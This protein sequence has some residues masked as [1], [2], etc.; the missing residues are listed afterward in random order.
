M[1]SFLGTEL[2]II[3]APMAGVQGAELCIAVSQ[4]GGLGSLPC[5]MLTP[6]SVATAIDQIRSATDKPFNLNFFCHEMPEVSDEQLSNWQKLFNED[7]KKFDLAPTLNGSVRQP[8]NSAFAEVVEALRPPI[9]SFHFGLPETSLLDRVRASGAKIMSS[10]TTVEEA[11]WLSNQGVDAIIVQGVEAGGHRGMFLTQSLESQR[12]TRTLLTDC[13]KVVNTPLIAAGGIASSK[14]VKQL[15]TLGAS[16]VQIGTSYL[17]C[18]E[19]NTSKLHRAALK[20]SDHPDTVL[21][22]IFSG[23][24]AR[25]IVNAMVE[26]LG[27]INPSAPPFPYAA[28]ASAPLRTAAESVN[29]ADYTPLWSGM[30]TGGCEA[31]SASE[32]TRKFARDLQ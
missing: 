11:Q 15:I 17:L 4:A 23:R 25:G 14:E 8:F 13:L 20:R 18:D 2:P 30:N 26:K 29:T 9:V 32:L 31:I 3:Q 10:A 22:N 6:E 16:A 5:A 28:L 24:P 7:Y 19:T 27:A 12:P 1:D 21:T